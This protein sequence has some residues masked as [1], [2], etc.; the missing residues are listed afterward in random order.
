MNLGSIIVANTLQHLQYDVDYMDIAAAFGVAISSESRKKQRQFIENI[1]AKKHYP[2]VCISCGCCLE[3]VATKRVASIVKSINPKAIVLVGGYQ[4][5]CDPVETLRD[6]HDVDVIVM[7]DFEPIAK[8]LIEAI[9]SKS[10]AGLKEIPNIVY[11]DGSKRIV[12]NERVYIRFDYNKHSVPLDLEPLRQYI[13]NYAIYAIEASRGCRYQCTFCAEPTMRRY[14]SVKPVE[15]V[16]SDIIYTVNY[17]A[18]YLPQNTTI[19]LIFTDPLWGGN[20]K[21]LKQFCSR[22]I[23]IKSENKIAPF[24]WG[25]AARIDQFSEDECRLMYK[26]GCRSLFYGVESFSA[27]SLEIMKK[28]T[29]RDKYVRSI[30]KHL[31]LTSKAGIYPEIGLLFG[32]PGDTFDELIENLDGYSKVKHIP[33]LEQP[34]FHFPIPY[35]GTELWRQ[36]DD[37]DLITKHGLEL[38]VQ[39]RWWRDGIPPEIPMFNPGRQLTAKKLVKFY[40]RSRDKLLAELKDE[41]GQLSYEDI[42]VAQGLLVERFIPNYK[43]KEVA[44]QVREMLTRDNNFQSAWSLH[45]PKSQ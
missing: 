37:K 29:N 2:I 13:G 17:V 20:K 24:I 12:E 40:E 4:A 15:H 7:G 5:A 39:R 30:K 38:T 41:K 11:K 45:R 35:A 25:C 16:V 28:T 22:I 6:M 1:Y 34:H 19:G 33:G 43:L 31:E 42:P 18:K 21:W 36:L 23:E 32:F 3:Y 9:V 10:E 44:E 26:A 8:D 27:K 14:Y